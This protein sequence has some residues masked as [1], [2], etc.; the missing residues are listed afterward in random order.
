MR[1]RAAIVTLMGLIAGVG[2]FA[3]GPPAQ[4][5][6]SFG[7]VKQSLQA[8]IKQGSTSTDSSVSFLSRDI[9]YVGDPKARIPFVEMIS[10][11]G[12][13]SVRTRLP[14]TGQPD[15]PQ[16]DV[17]EI[18]G[19][20]KDACESGGGVLERRDPPWWP[21]PTRTPVVGRGFKAL[22]NEGLIGQFWCQASQGPVLFMVEVTPS[23]E[24]SSPPFSLGWNW[25]IAFQLVSP[26]ALE[27]H[28]G[29]R[30][31]YEKSVADLRGNLKV[32]AQ[33]Q[34]QTS[35]LPDA[36]TGEWRA[37]HGDWVGTMCGLVTDVKGPIA[38]VQIQSTQLAIEAQHLFP[39]ANKK[40]IGDLMSVDR[41]QPQTWC[42]R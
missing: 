7:A 18:T 11:L 2:A 39:Q 5:A 41:Y 1:I 24:A 17:A 6:G 36:L 10:T 9:T 14:V 4:D 40:G 8:L 31:E 25:N 15:R 12:G 30:H 16:K 34:I 19:R 13:L 29:R 21:E 20:I 32:G 35:E 23:S 22:I 26:G 38:Q 42:I 27:K 33:V 28:E 37:R 3:E